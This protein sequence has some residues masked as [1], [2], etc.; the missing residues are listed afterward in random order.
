MKTFSIENLVSY[1]VLL[2]LEFELW[3]MFAQMRSVILK[4]F[5]IENLVSY[6]V[7]LDLGFELWPNAQ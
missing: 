4:T 2:R 6:F 7:L 5:S 3:P 1:F